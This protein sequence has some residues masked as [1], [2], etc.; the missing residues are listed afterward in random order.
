MTNPP[1]KFACLLWGGYANG[2]TGDEI[3]LAA[4]LERKQHE[5][6]GNVAILSHLPEYTSKLFP[7]ATIIPY[8]SSQPKSSR[9]RRKRFFRACKFFIAKFISFL[10]NGQ[11]DPGWAWK[12]HLTHTSELYLVGGGYLADLFPIDFFM[13]PIQFALKLNIPVATAPIGVG[14]F[15]SSLCADQVTAALRQI[16]LTVRDQTSLD[17][18][19][20]RDIN[21]SLEPDDAFAFL[22]NLSRFAPAIQP[23]IRPRKIGVC[24][25]KQYGQ[26]ANCDLNAWWAECLRGLKAQHPEYDIEGFCFHTSLEAEFQEMT[27]LFSLAG[28]LPERVLTP[29]LDFRRAVEIVRD[30]D[31][32]ISTRFHATITANVL[33]I[34]NVAIAV[35]D[36]YQAKMSAA[37]LAYENISSLLNPASQSPEELLKMCKSRLAGGKN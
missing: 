19:R 8:V 9:F 10:R 2:N 7:H 11:W 35:D 12:Q 30:Y 31:L 34:P 18:C 14:P 17:F 6:N 21:A 28:L 36:Y 1:K 13:S 20:A 25:F 24:I 4:A 23:G 3:C 37:R 33:N 5:F 32:V 15:K 26:D 27:R 22:K 29:V 16:K